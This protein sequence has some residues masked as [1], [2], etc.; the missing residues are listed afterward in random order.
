VGSARKRARPKEP[1]GGAGGK[2]RRVGA[3]A[4]FKGS[5]KLEDSY[6]SS[7]ESGP[8]DVRARAATRADEVWSRPFGS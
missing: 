1:Q 4:S 8:E 2:R 3:A 6:S 7:D 5:Y